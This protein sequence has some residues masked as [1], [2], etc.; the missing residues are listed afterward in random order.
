[1]LA[2]GNG[3]MMRENQSWSSPQE[4]L[5]SRLDAAD[6]QLDDLL[7]ANAPRDVP[8][9]LA[10][11]VARASLG[12]LEQG[13]TSRPRQLVFGQAARL[14]AA[15]AIAAALVGVFW[16]M[17]PTP[18]LPKIE[19]MQPVAQVPEP[20]DHSRTPFERFRGLQMVESM[21][22]GDAMDGLESVVAAIQSGASS[23]LILSEGDQDRDLFENELDAVRVVASLGG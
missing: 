16:L 6:R 13:R 9:G 11:R 7:D 10:H 5:D 17:G 18:E 21:Q 14:A 19:L 12:H 23:Y 1:M 20:L 22:Y 2:V 3:L 4:P 8:E 15:A